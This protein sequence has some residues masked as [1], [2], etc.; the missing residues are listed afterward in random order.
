MAFVTDKG[1]NLWYEIKGQGQPLV[2]SGGFGLLHNQWD[3]VTDLLAQH[4]Q[5][6]NWN[7]RGSGQSDRA[8][9]GKS[10]NQD[11]WVDDLEIILDALDIKDAVL[12]GTSTG[13]PTSIR[14]TAR[15]QDRV[16]ALITYPMF[17]A[18]PGFRKAFSYFSGVCETFGYDALACLT[19]WIGCAAENVFQPKQG[20]MAKWEAECFERNFAIETIDEIMS[21]CSTNDFTS[22]LAK[23]TVPTLV[24]MGESGVLGTNNPAN[25]AL[26]DEFLQHVSGGAA[27]NHTQGRWHLLH[28]R[29]AG[30]NRAGGD[31]LYIH[32]LNRLCPVPGNV[33][34]PRVARVPGLFNPYWPT[35]YP[36]THR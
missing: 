1:V 20:E 31:R 26:A 10:Y 23:I 24:L 25:K 33:K 30:E 35:D 7:Y 29:A 11:T 18:D 32:P 17:K 15:Y 3:F 9:P 5:V 2:L 27:K 19:T 13:S 12:W 6:I 21:I 36:S 14:Y 8:W 16:K 22:D 4:Y 34:K 28:D